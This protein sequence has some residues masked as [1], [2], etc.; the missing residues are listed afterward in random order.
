M[1]RAL[2][3]IQQERKTPKKEDPF[4]LEACEVVHEVM[5]STLERRRKLLQRLDE[6]AQIERQIA[7]NAK[8]D[9][10]DP[11]EAVLAARAKFFRSG[12]TPADD[13]V[14]A[15]LP[16]SERKA[17]DE[18]HK[19]N[20]A[21]KDD[22]RSM[23]PG[24]ASKGTYDGLW[25][26]DW[27]EQ[28][29]D[30]WVSLDDIFKVL[31]RGKNRP[32]GYRNPDLKWA[33][34]NSWRI[35][36]LVFADG[37]IGD[38]KSST[39]MRG[40]L[41]AGGDEVNLGFVAFANNPAL[42]L[43]GD[44]TPA[45]PKAQWYQWG[46]VLMRPPH[47]GLPEKNW[48]GTPMDYVRQ[49]APLTVAYGAG[50]D[51]TAM[52]VQFVRMG[53]R[54]ELILF[55]DVGSEKP[56]TY[57]YLEYFDKWLQSK[58]FPEVT[59]VRY[60]MTEA[61]I[62]ARKNRVAREEDED[63]DLGNRPI[64][65]REY[66]TIEQNMIYNRTYPSLAFG[67]QRHSC[68]SKWKLGPQ[69]AFIEHHEEF[70]PIAQAA[71]DAGLPV[72]R[73]IG[74]DASAGDKGR[75]DRTPDDVHYLHWYPLQ[76]WNWDRETCKKEIAAE[77]LKVP[78]KSAC[79]FC[80]SSHDVELA[81][82]VWSHPQFVEKIR[83][84][85]NKGRP[86][87]EKGPFQGLWY[88][89]DKLPEPIK[90]AHPYGYDYWFQEGKVTP[91]EADYFIKV[92]WGGEPEYDKSKGG[93]GKANTKPGRMTDFV[94][95]YRRLCKQQP[96]HKWCDPDYL[97]QAHDPCPVMPNP[98]ELLD[99]SFDYVHPAVR[100]EIDDAVERALAAGAEAPLTYAGAGAYGIVI[101]DSNGIAYKVARHG[102][103]GFTAR[104]LMEEELWFRFAAKIPSIRDHVA[105]VYRFDSN[106][107][108][109]VRECVQP[110]HD[111]G[112]DWE[113]KR[114]RRRL[115]LYNRIIAAMRPYG[116]RSPE[117]KEDSFVYDP[118][119][120]PVLVDAGFASRDIG[121]SNARRARALIAGAIPV[122]DFEVSQVA[123]GLRMDAG[124]EVP[125][126]VANRLAETLEAT[127][128]QQ[129]PYVYPE[130]EADPQLDAKTR[131][132]VE[133]LGVD[134]AAWFDLAVRVGPNHPRYLE[135]IHRSNEAI[136][137][138]HE[139]EV[140]AGKT[141]EIEWETA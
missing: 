93:I 82:M 26:I 124:R 133:R 129:N 95:V 56:E 83:E 3:I 140:A 114:D 1:H 19:W 130:R 102:A 70:A 98:I 137:E 39:T 37:D 72:I 46:P 71:W 111:R 43:P 108:V 53:L 11:D 107:G 68:S 55:A 109:L 44:L 134:A 113:G 17:F 57:E 35:G 90:A 13:E 16:K 49:G 9:G 131:R 18:A 141:W 80:P 22:V 27:A 103:H 91:T 61:G 63:D 8:R 66:K 24:G 127:R 52:L 42:V 88:M 32:T 87:N 75:R 132:D 86:Y 40:R 96:D 78:V 6:W 28:G 15:E 128:L 20:A 21:N 125:V 4:D 100:D 112:R 94:E 116:F 123:H 23:I 118:R 121:W 34:F 12:R 41:K 138:I 36:S 50:V 84:M 29:L 73:C 45:M 76:D 115:D 5:G 54:P 64:D 139:L 101:C 85:E 97:E 126:A 110:R 62:K 106:N 77:G 79:Y 120:G 60:A 65:P 74:F 135:Y 67:F 92:K 33:I 58:G 59:V 105:K 89:G 7:S 10:E 99:E 48:P 136:A 122:N 81:K 31:K 47:P 2:P 119:R 14:R 104:S 25:E 38:R 69:L 117:Y 51:S 30:Q